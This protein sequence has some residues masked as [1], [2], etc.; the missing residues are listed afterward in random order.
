MGV[1][2]DELGEFRSEAMEL[3]EETEKN[4]LSIEGGEDF[5][6]NFDSIFRVFHNLKGA[7]G[8]M[9]LDDLGELMH[10]LENQLNSTKDLQSMSKEQV[11]FFLKGVDQARAML[12][13][14]ADQVVAAETKPDPSSEVVEAVEEVQVATVPLSESVLEFL[15]EAIEIS[16]RISQ[17]LLGIEKDKVEDS[18]ID[19]LYRDVHTLKGGA[20]LFNFKGLGDLNHAIET[21]LD[22]LRTHRLSISKPLIDALFVGLDLIDLCLQEIQGQVHEDLEERIHKSIGFFNLYVSTHIIADAEKS[23]EAPSAVLSA[24]PAQASASAPAS[25]GA[26]DADKE[27]GGT[28]RVQV[29]LLDKLMTLMGEMVLVR[30]QVIQYSNRT[31]DL[32]FLNLSQR[33]SVVTGEIQGE[34]M[35][36]RMQPIGNVLSKFSRL[37]RELSKDLGKKIEMHLTGSETELDK[38]LLEAVKDPLTHIVRNSCDH[39][40]ESPDERKAAGKPEVGNI[41]VNSYHEGGQVIIEIADDGKGLHRDRLL[42]KAIEK[43]IVTPERASALSDREIVHLIFAPGFSTAAMVTNVSGRGVG[44]DVVRTNI[45]KIGGSVEIESEPGV[46]TTL[47]LKIPLTLAIVPALVVSCKGDFFAIP[48]LKLVELV[49]VDQ[50]SSVNKIESIQGHP[51]YRL[52][53]N[54]LPLINIRKVL[55]TSDK[56]EPSSDVANIVVLKSD[57]FCFGLVVDEIQDTA[58][59]VVKPLA[60][61]LKPISVYSGATVMGDGSIALILDVAGIVSEHISTAGGPVHGRIDEDLEASKLRL[62]DQQDFLLF[63]VGS[64]SKHALLLGYVHRLEEFRREAVEVSGHRRLVRYRNSVLPLLSVDK[65]LGLEKSTAPTG[66]VISVVV[67][68]KAGALYGLE[69]NEILDVLSTQAELDTTVISPEGVVGNLVTD[70]EIVVVVDPYKIIQS[71]MGLEAKAIKIPQILQIRA[72]SGMTPLKSQNSGQSKILY[73]EDA[74]FF[75]RHISKVLKEAGF[76]VTM[77]NNGKEACDLLAKSEDHAFDVILSDI[78]MPVMNGFEFAKALRKN[79]KWAH[80][81]LIALSTRSDQSHIEQGRQVGFNAYLEKVNSEELLET[82][83]GFSRKGVA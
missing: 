80:I 37:T 7:S 71:E 33:L 50:S 63:R 51:V 69:V 82:I 32:E 21:V 9:G 26:G 35:K 65:A 4:L 39:G 61:F 30:N 47:R 76:S 54:I 16:Q 5:K 34:M 45:E 41:R 67:I 64:K 60:R 56:D 1:H 57:Q 78:E 79:Q 38:T 40:I 73:I 28:V 14:S 10:Q 75:R 53:G 81:P 24:T 43:G 77:V 19:A 66:D 36:T 59:I 8:M 29:S 22:G 44:M 25:A 48:Q 62:H 74:V 68:E 31:D 18:A 42:K 27:G 17:S 20:Y 15:I 12:G 23:V 3:L 72:E 55:G 2:D 49:R 13:A 6:V 11:D 46:G 58:D 83:T 52:R 70:Q